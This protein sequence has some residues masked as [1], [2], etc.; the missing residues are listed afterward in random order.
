ME[1]NG[2]AMEWNGM[3]WICNGMEWNGILDASVDSL[4][5]KSGWKPSVEL[6]GALLAGHTAKARHKA[7]IPGREKDVTK[8][9]AFLRKYSLLKKSPTLFL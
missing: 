6:A 3:E 4:S 2:I 7:G 8:G 1:W 9:E 5:E